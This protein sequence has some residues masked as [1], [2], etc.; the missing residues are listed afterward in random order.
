MRCVCLVHHQL[1]AGVLVDCHSETTLTRNMDRL[2]ASGLAD[3]IDRYGLVANG[4][5]DT[6]NRVDVSIH[7]HEQVGVVD[8]LVVLSHDTA[9]ATNAVG[10]QPKPVGVTRG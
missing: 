3:L 6:V 10:Q 9:P 4:I 1:D 8:E 2:S 5:H 7:G